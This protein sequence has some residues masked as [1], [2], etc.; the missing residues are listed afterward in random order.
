MSPQSTDAPTSRPRAHVGLWCCLAFAS[1]FVAHASPLAWEPLSGMYGGGVDEVIA[2]RGGGLLARAGGG[3]WRSPDRGDSW[4]PAPDQTH[5]WVAVGGAVYGISPDGV[6]ASHDAGRTWR[7]TGLTVSPR[8]LAVSG[9][10]VYALSETRV[11]R[12]GDGAWHE[13]GDVAGL[14]EIWSRV[15]YGDQ[16][17]SSAVTT[18]SSF[19]TPSLKVTPPATSASNSDLLSRRHRP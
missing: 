4:A 3:V 6:L 2:L 9:D 14:G 13:I 7:P 15:V 19:L 12:F 17:A 11:F 10:T 1:T 16:A 18:S 5:G 8:A